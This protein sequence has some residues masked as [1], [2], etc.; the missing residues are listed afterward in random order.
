VA[1]GA[2][3]AAFVAGLLFNPP[4]RFAPEDNLTYRDYVLLHRQA[5]AYLTQHAH[6]ARVLTAWPASDEISQPFLG[7]V[8][9]TIPVV[10]IDNFDGEQME[11]AA[12]AQG[13][14][15]WA[16]LFST[17]YEPPRLP[18]HSAFWERMQQKY[19]DYHADIAPEVAA[20]MIGGRIVF[21]A[22]RRGEWVALVQI[23]HVENAELQSRP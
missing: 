3:I 23:E 11:M 10:R 6:G 8:K 13:Q 9:Q 22:Q 21:R 20:Q 14:Y 2:V 15:D 12:A 4:Y 18:W 17:K 19:F 7:Y 1:I 16:Y 5:A